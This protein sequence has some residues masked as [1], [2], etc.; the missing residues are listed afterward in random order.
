MKTP[1]SPLAGTS[2]E[3]NGAELAASGAITIPIAAT[4]PLEKV[5]TAYKQVEQRHTRGKIALVPG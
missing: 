1:L 4:Y 3:T 2:V 5:R